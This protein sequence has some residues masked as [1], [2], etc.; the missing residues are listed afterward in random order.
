MI[1]PGDR[2]AASFLDR[3]SEDLIGRID[4]LFGAAIEFVAEPA[5]SGGQQEALVGKPSGGIDSEFE[6]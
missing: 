6:A 5:L 1:P 3:E 2:E 4:Q